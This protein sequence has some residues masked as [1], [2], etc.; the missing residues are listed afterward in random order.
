LVPTEI[1]FKVDDNNTDW[2]SLEHD[3]V[4]MGY[5]NVISRLPGWKGVSTEFKE[6]WHSLRLRKDTFVQYGGIYSDFVKFIQTKFKGKVTYNMLRNNKVTHA[7]YRQDAA[8]HG[9]DYYKTV[10]CH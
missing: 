4:E 2:I 3:K 7:A 10:E 6:L 1:F 9:L 5:V 8:L